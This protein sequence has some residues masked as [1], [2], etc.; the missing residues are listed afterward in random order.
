[1][2]VLLVVP[3]YGD[4]NKVNY[5]YPFPLGLGYI[6]SV[7]KKAG[8]DVQCLNLNHLQGEIEELMEKAINENN[9]DVICTGHMAIGYHIIKNIIDAVRKKNYPGKIILGGPIIT[10]EPEIIFQ[11]LNPD[12]GVLGEGEITI[13]ELLDSLE[14][15]KDLK[16]V[17]GIIYKNKEG[18]AVITEKR[19]VI[20]D[21]DSLP[22]PDLESFGYKDWLED[23]CTND[24]FDSNLLDN[25]RTYQI[26][27]SRSCPYQCTF[28][29]HPLGSKYRTRSLDN[30]MKEI[31]EAIEKY[32]I[33]NIYFFD[34]LFSIDRKRLNDFCEKIK[35]IIDKTPWKITWTCQLSVNAIDKELLQRLKDSG[36]EIACFGFESVS[37]EVLKSMRKPVTPEQ[38]DNAIKLCLNIKLAIQGGFIFGDIA[39]TMETA[40][41]TLEYWK[42][43][44]MGQAG[45]GFIQPYPNSE[46]YLNCVKRGIIKDKLEFIK[47]LGDEKILNMTEHMNNKEFEQLK[48]EIEK[49]SIISRKSVIPNKI[50]YTSEEKYEVEVKCP[51]CN[52]KIVYKN[53]RIKNKNYFS[54]FITC[55]NCKMRFMIKSRLKNFVQNPV[56]YPRLYNL[57]KLYKEARKKKKGS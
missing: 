8:H 25:P 45:V 44:C 23:K 13:V 6:F 52:E 34:D 51:F 41:E 7:I 22:F 42:K 38:I 11:D 43:E 9:Y 16:E 32:Q 40:R 50:T 47:N 39:E 14:K 31:E 36:C 20:E 4:T 24:S 57:M 5:N 33:N 15:N 26:L 29:Y 54:S 56:T 18:E 12:Y 28:C 35:K 55:R 10:S 53:F 48:K 46:I 17:K 27:C 2:K 1:M 21:L 37:K 3:K 49:E 19:P 30:V